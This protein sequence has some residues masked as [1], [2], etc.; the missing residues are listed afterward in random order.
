MSSTMDFAL[1]PDTMADDEA[2][3]FSTQQERASDASEIELR[4]LVSSTASA[5]QQVEVP[6]RITELHNDTS[7]AASPGDIDEPIPKGESSLHSPGSGMRT[8]HTSILKAL[9]FDSWIGRP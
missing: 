3:S 9:L 5:M 6:E 7:T 2:R 1:R 4:P 8:K